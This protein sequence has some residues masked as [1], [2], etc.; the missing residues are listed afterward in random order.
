MF[1]CSTCTLI[2]WERGRI[3]LEDK[4]SEDNTIYVLQFGKYFICP[5]IL[6]WYEALPD[7]KSG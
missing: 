7:I 4:S 3:A 5:V 1:L 6:V 2:S